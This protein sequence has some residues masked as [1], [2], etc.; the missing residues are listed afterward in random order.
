MLYASTVV[1]QVRALLDAGVPP[2]HVTVVG[3]SKGGG[4][5]VAASSMLARDDVNFVFIA[6]CAPWLDEH[7]EIVGRGRLLALREV[8]DSLAGSCRGLFDRS[9]SAHEHREVLLDLGGG[10]GAFYRPH[11]KWIDPIVEWAIRQ[12]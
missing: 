9:P 2:D 7:P 1:E 4:I 8:S 5:A 6:A 11:A 3:F 10:H 12:E